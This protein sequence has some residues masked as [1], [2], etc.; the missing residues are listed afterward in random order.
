MRRVNRCMLSLVLITALVLP[1]VAQ[2]AKPKACVI[3]LDGTIADET[4]RR[5][6]AEAECPKEKDKKGYYKIYFDPALIAGDKPIEKAREVLKWVDDQDIDIYYVSS[7]NRSCLAAS[8]K[9]IEDNGFPEGKGVI[10]QERPEKS[11]PYKTRAIKGIQEKADVLFGVGDQGTDIEAYENC[12]IKAI[13]VEA[14]SSKD[15]ERVK[16]EIK[17][18]LAEKK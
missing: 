15:W 13:K 14:N 6:K 5:A 17:K 10:H 3:D 4:A 11:V 9:W 8:E 7:R 12:G 1:A 18:V 2:E 16:G